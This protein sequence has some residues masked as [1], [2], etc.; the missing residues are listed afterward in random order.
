MNGKPE[1]T[2]LAAASVPQPR[3]LRRDAERN[4]RLILEAAKVVFAQRG[5]DASL[6]EIAREADLGVGTVYRRFPNRDALIDAL[7]DDM[8]GSIKRV[9]D[10]AV[11]LPRGWDGLVHFMTA[12]LETQAHDKGL[13]DAL[14]AQQAHLH[15]VGHEKSQ[16]IREVVQPMLIDLVSRAQQEGELRSDVAATDIGVLLIAGVCMLEFTAPVATENWRRHLS[17]V[18][19][20]LRARPEGANTP[21]AEPPLDDDQIDACMQGWKYSTREAVRRRSKTP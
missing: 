15:E 18:L 8:V 4:R 7:F 9:A 3:P 20:G 5:L 21:L 14:I 2:V 1:V 17:I 10:E 11:A 16:V 6:D 12:M 19:D 13:R